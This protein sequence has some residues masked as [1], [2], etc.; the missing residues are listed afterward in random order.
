MKKNFHVQ[1]AA[2][3]SSR[4]DA[5]MEYASEVGVNAYVRVKLSFLQKEVGF[6]VHWERSEFCSSTHFEGGR[7]VE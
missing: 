7:G 4:F 3:V 6:F 5:G 2:V 1:A